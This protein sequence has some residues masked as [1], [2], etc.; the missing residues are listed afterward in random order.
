VEK[1]SRECVWCFVLIWSQIRGAQRT[2]VS[3]LKPLDYVRPVNGQLWER[4]EKCLHRFV[5]FIC[6]KMFPLQ[7]LKRRSHWASTVLCLALL[8]VQGGPK[9]KPLPNYRKIVLKPVN[10]IR[11][12]RQIKV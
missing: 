7:G 6:K 1:T 9:S 2:F 4:V 12:S 3:E 11:F 8:Y 10:E 5:I